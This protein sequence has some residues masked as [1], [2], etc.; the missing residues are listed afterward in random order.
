[1]LHEVLHTLAHCLFRI[2]VFVCAAHKKEKDSAS[3]QS[4]CIPLEPVN[5]S[6]KRIAFSAGRKRQHESSPPPFSASPTKIKCTPASNSMPTSP[7]IVAGS[8]SS[9]T[10][11]RLLSEPSTM[12]KLSKNSHARVTREE[13]HLESSRK[14]DQEKIPGGVEAVGVRDDRETAKVAIVVPRKTPQTKEEDIERKVKL[15]YA[16]SVVNVSSHVSLLLLY[17][18]HVS[19]LKGTW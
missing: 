18:L 16:L 4:T 17:V 14:E 19:M 5:V 9:R 13:V 3:L 6:L 1:M 12:P 10:L 8:K 11:K 7:D 2:Y 15:D